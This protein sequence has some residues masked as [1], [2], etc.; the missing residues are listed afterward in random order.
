MK[1]L[2][3]LFAVLPLFAFGQNAD[4][5]LANT[6]SGP[7]G[8]CQVDSANVSI[9]IVN[10]SAFPFSGNVELGYQLNGGTPHTENTSITLMANSTYF[11]TFS[12]PLVLQTCQM[13]EIKSWV[14]YA[15]DPNH[16]NDTTVYQIASD[17][18]AMAGDFMGDTTGCISGVDS[19]CHDNYTGN[20]VDWWTSNDGGITWNMSGDTT[21]CFDVTALSPDTEVMVMIDSEFG[22]CAGD[23]AQVTVNCTL[24]VPEKLTPEL[25]VSH[26]ITNEQPWLIQGLN[27]YSAHE[28]KVFDLNGKL[29]F[30][31]NNYNNQWKA[32]E[33]PSGLYVYQINLNN[34]THSGKVVVQH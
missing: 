33:I 14:Y 25:T 8:G 7:S 19:V 24:A 10:L 34:Q 5:T 11:Y 17:C 6:L 13:N 26:Q 2:L 3:T 32:H 28:I 22:F 4:L 30:T 27:A 16:A 23:S 1:K 9:I 15:N 29:V 12:I 21:D 18:P 31:S 20:I